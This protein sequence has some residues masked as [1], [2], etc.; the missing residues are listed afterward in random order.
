MVAAVMARA[1]LSIATR[2]HLLFHSRRLTG[3]SGVA[4][5]GVVP[6]RPLVHPSTSRDM[7]WRIPVG[8]AP[9]PAGQ[10]AD[11]WILLM[12]SMSIDTGRCFARMG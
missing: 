9:T 1:S 6:E 8:G 7:S 5:H 10:G 11:G 2:S 3:S 4:K 12:T